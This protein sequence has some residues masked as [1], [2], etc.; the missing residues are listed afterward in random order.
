MTNFILKF[1]QTNFKRLFFCLLC[2]SMLGLASRANA[3]C[4][5]NGAATGAKDGSSWTDAYTNPQFA[6]LKPDTCPEIWVAKGVYKP[7][8]GTDQSVSFVLPAGVTFYGG[9]IGTETSRDQ[10]VPA[11]N[12]TV[13]SGDIDNNDANAGGSQVDTTRD[14]INGANS[15]HVVYADG[16]SDAPVLSSTLIDGFTITGGNAKDIGGGGFYCNAEG[17]DRGEC[18]PTLRNIIFSGNTTDKDGGGMYNDASAGGVSSPTLIDITF[19][20]NLALGNGGA[21]YDNGDQGISSPTLTNV[22]FNG[23]SAT[24]GGAMYNLG[25]DVNAGVPGTSS[26]TLSSVVFAGN[27]AETGGAMSNVSNEGGICKPVL[28]IVTFNGNRVRGLGAGALYNGSDGSGSITSPTVINSTFSDNH[29][30]GSGG[31]ILNISSAEGTTRPFITN[32]TFSGNQSDLGGA[33]YNSASTSLTT[34][35]LT[36]VILWADSASSDPS[37]NEIGE[38]NSTLSIVQSVVQGGCPSGATAV[39]SNVSKADPKLSAL[40]ENGG[41]TRTMVPQYGSSAIDTGLDSFCPN[42]DQRG[43]SRPQGPHCEI[44][45]VEV[46][47]TP[48][49]VA[50]PKSVIIPE[51]TSI[52]ITLT[53]SDSNP[54]G[55]FSFTITGAVKHGSVLIADNVVT[56]RPSTN[57]TGPDSFLYTATDTN[58]TSLPATVTI[59]VTSGPPVADPKNILVPH[60]TSKDVTLS[61]TDNNV[62]TFTY[63]FAMATSAAHGTVSPSGDTAT[64]TPLHNYTGPDSFTYTATD[65]NGTSLPATVTIQVAPAPPV[66]DNKIVTTPYNTP[67]QITLSGSDNDNLG[68]PFSLTFALASSPAHGT[69]SAI[70]GSIVTYTPNHNYSGPDSFTYNTTDINGES[71]PALVQITVLPPGVIPPPPTRTTAIPTLSTWSLL[72]LAGLIGLTT[73][74]RKRKV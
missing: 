23:N 36:N 31:A 24:E 54:G 15:F 59:Q 43:L 13:L 7:T 41:F 16:P 10:R 9:F 4:Y 2:M 44:G 32:V 29:A 42:V 21:I 28:S 27:L 25:S 74:G 5:V 26:P 69:F 48:P 1:K 55:L 12:L 51:N 58:G 3:V 71:T 60:N 22:F 35:L 49:P 50:D 73:V 53:A 46:I 33:I 61:A 66:A 47:P 45:A 17:N 63:T 72:A 62:G 14:D 70:S 37:T 19:S 6:L 30:D 18:S 57:Y 20:G 40:S 56:Y 64:Y 8:L 68:G 67:K 38:T 65:V 11:V 39:C 34:L 52:Q